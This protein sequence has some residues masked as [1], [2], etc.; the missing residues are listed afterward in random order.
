[1]VPMHYKQIIP[2]KITGRSKKCCQIRWWN[3]IQC[4]LTEYQKQM[5]Y[6]LKYL[7]VTATH[8]LYNH[9]FSCTHAVKAGCTSFALQ[10]A[11]CKQNSY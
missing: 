10:Y 7:L 11:R 8:A 6:D 9:S 2:I 3:R 4:I 1:M 5:I